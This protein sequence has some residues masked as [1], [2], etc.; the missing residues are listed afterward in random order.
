[1]GDHEQVPI[2]DAPKGPSLSILSQALLGDAGHPPF[3]PP[4]KSPA[5]LPE[6]GFA[7]LNPEAPSLPGTLLCGL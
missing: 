3:R 5:P 6:K 2:W 7:N 4:A 1:M